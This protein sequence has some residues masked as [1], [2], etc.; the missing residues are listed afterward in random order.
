MHGQYDLR[1]QAGQERTPRPPPSLVVSRI[2]A[3]RQALDLRQRAERILGIDDLNLQAELP[4][5]PALDQVTLAERL[6]L[7]QIHDVPLAE[8][9]EDLRWRGSRRGA[10]EAVCAEIGETELAARMPLW[11]ES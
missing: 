10:L 7:R 4:L 8:M 6:H 9:L 1:R 3:G 5:L 11:R 2:L